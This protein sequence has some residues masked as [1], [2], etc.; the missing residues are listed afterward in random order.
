MKPKTGTLV[1][2]KDGN[3]KVRTG[4]IKPGDRRIKAVTKQESGAWK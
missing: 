2:T 3:L 1:R 4:D